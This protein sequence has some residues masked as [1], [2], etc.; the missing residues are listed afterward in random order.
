[1]SECSNSSQLQQ[2]QEMIFAEE[3]VKD[4]GGE[5]EVVQGDG[6]RGS[7]DARLQLQILPSQVDNFFVYL[8]KYSLVIGILFNHRKSNHFESLNMYLPENFNLF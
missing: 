5:Q 1:M 3:E 6:G 8:N 7:Q 4:V 2:N